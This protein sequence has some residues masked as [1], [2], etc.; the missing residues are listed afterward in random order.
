MEALRQIADWP[1][2]FAAAGALVD[3]TEAVRADERLNEP[4]G[5]LGDGQVKVAL[6]G[7]P[8]F[9]G[10]FNAVNKEGMLRAELLTWPVT[11]LILVLA[12]GTLAAAG[13]KTL[14]VDR[15]AFPRNKP[16]GGGISERA[17]RRFPWL[18][19]TLAGID[20]HRLSRLRLEAPDGGA[21]DLESD[22][23]CVLLIRR[24]EFDQALVA[25]A[26]E[27]GATLVAG[28]EIGQAEMGP[29]GVTPA[30]DAVLAR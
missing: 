6:T 19:A 18:S 15:A 8:A 13:L 14:L 7:S 30:I 24:V 27:A 10:D 23:S 25:A 11:A 3:P 4:I 12:F 17:L 22:R 29:D 5:R 26:Q 20:V 1:V 9:W 16:C 28:F 21:L 2:P